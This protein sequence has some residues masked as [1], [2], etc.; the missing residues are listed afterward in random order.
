[1]SVTILDLNWFISYGTFPFPASSEMR[2]PRWKEEKVLF[3]TT[4][5]IHHYRQWLRGTVIQIKRHIAQF[6]TFLL[7]CPLSSVIVVQS[8][9]FLRHKQVRS[10]LLSASIELIARAKFEILNLTEQKGTNKITEEIFHT[11]YGEQIF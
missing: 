6:L 9:K 1:M 8:T 3:T 2:V 4:G 5:P 11:N 10:L 7:K